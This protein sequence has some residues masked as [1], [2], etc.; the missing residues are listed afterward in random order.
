MK[1]KITPVA[2]ATSPD[3]GEDVRVDDTGPDTPLRK[4]SRELADRLPE[5]MIRR[6]K[7]PT[8]IRECREVFMMEI[9]SRDEVEAA[10]MA[11]ATMSAIE[12]GSIRLSA[13]AERR[14]CIRLAIVGLGKLSDRRDASSPIVYTHVNHDGVP[15]ADIND[16]SGKAWTALQTWF[17]T[18]NGVPAEELAEGLAGAETVGAYA[19]PTS[20]IRASAE[21]GK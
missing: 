19:P 3:H 4:F 1:K 7:M 14:E 2:R 15:F 21:S 10:I 20:A 12:K 13:D 9:T 17:G 6:Y 8:A 5:R 11:D 16:W 18:L